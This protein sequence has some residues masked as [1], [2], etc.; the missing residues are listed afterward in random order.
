LVGAGRL[1]SPE[2]HAFESREESVQIHFFSGV[3]ERGRRQAVVWFDS[4]AGYAAESSR[5]PSSPIDRNPRTSEVGLPRLALTS[6]GLARCCARKRCGVRDEPCVVFG[7]FRVI[8]P[9]PTR[10]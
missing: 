1:G 3:D 7:P 2:S 6:G 4:D 9:E 10:L 8:P 5:V